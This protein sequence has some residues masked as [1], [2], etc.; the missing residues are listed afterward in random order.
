VEGWLF[1]ILIV[2]PA[3]LWAGKGLE[4]LLTVMA[5]HRWR[6]SSLPA[7]SNLTSTT[8][9]AALSGLGIF[10]VL[11]VVSLLL[12]QEALWL[13]VLTM[14]LGSAILSWGLWSLAHIRSWWL[15][16]SGCPLRAEL[17]VLAQKMNIKPGRVRLRM[18]EVLIPRV[19]LDGSIELSTGFLEN[20]PSEEQE[21]LLATALYTQNKKIVNKNY[22]LCFTAILGYFL[23]IA[24]FDEISH[25]M[26]K[27]IRGLIPF[28]GP[29]F[30][31]LVFQ[32][33]LM[34][35]YA[36]PAMKSAL[37]ITGN[38]EAA[39]S[40]VRRVDSINADRRLSELRQWWAERQIALPNAVATSPLP[41][42]T[43]AIGKR[44]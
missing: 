43:Q 3:S 8:I 28:S 39:E 38:L 40:A 24:I 34:P 2:I 11:G 27:K 6:E 35:R 36:L 23:L 5:P 41:P 20:L 31:M 44:P 42:Q 16:D 10:G 7:V 9:G 12:L 26:F 18:S 17:D 13:R 33:V 21:F 37:L 15:L 32:L 1:E 30:G 29:I 22:L 14:I 25:R 19:F 4:H